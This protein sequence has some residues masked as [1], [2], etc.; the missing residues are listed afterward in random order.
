M[1]KTGLVLSGGGAR[2]IAHLGVLQGMREV[3]IEPA[4]ISGVSAGAIIGA[5]YAADYTPLQIMDMIKEY[6]SSSLAKMMLLP[7][8][9]FSAAGLKKILRSVISKDS[10]EALRIPL[11]VTTTDIISGTSVTFSQGQLFD[12]VVGSSSVPA[13]F[14]P[15]KH[16]GHYLV[17]GGVLNNFPVECLTGH[18]DRIIGSHVNKLYP[19][20]PKQLGRLKVLER[21]FHLAIAHTVKRNSSSVDLLIEPQLAKYGMFEMK[22]ARQIFEAGYSSL[23][24]NEELLLSWKEPGHPAGAGAGHDQ[25]KE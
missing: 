24:A 8:G 9:L 20:K 18:C 1:I 14:S 3:G 15:V 2:A 10:F 5:L 19:L 7:G 12:V 22:F 23:M 11:F 4:C 21:C 16:G 6:S 17:D 25:V 13:M